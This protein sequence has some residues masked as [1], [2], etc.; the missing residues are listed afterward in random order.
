M[1]ASR[2][3][4][5]ATLF[6]SLIWLISGIMASASVRGRGVRT[7]GGRGRGLTRVPFRTDNN[8]FALLSE[9][10]DNEDN[11][12][13]GEGSAM[14]TN[15]SLNSFLD[16]T[17]G[18]NN[19]IDGTGG[20]WNIVRSKQVKRQR[21]RSSDQSGQGM[22]IFENSLE[23]GTGDTE[24]YDSISTE[25]K[26]ALILSKLSLNEQRVK[27]IQHTL[28]ST[29]P[30]KKRV[31]KIE[32]VIRSH[33]ER[34]R[35]LEYRSLDSEARTRRRNLLFKGIPENRNENCFAEARH[36]IHEKL[37]IDEDMYLE[38]AHR[39][40]RFDGKQDRPIIVAFRD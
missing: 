24:D 38:R 28:D 14:D 17:G 12:Q 40:G 8:I 26:L 6:F 2:T 20:D 39:L 10:E 19:A 31:E 18:F 16:V 11:A 3:L 1:A 33:S 23:D 27:S 37:H 9:P 36:F 7:R 15:T 4:K 29:L 32:T 34:I 13:D 22:E 21:I 30:T 5:T 25:G 35:L